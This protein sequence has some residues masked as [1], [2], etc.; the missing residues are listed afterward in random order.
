MVATKLKV[1]KTVKKICKNNGVKPTTKKSVTIGKKRKLSRRNIIRGTKTAWIFFCNNNRLDVLSKNPKLSFGD[2]CKQLAPQ[3]KVMSSEEKKPYED[4][5]KAD[6]VRFITETS[7]LTDDEKRT[8]KQHKKKKRDE[9]KNNPKAGLSPYMYFVLK[10]RPDVVTEFPDF[11]FQSVGKLLG[12]KWNAMTLDEK[13]PFVTLS[14]IDKERYRVELAAKVASD[15]NS[16]TV[17][18]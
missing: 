18:K 5:H 8:L 15:I 17:K 13:T 7:N 1:N 16:A 4:L 6:K 9:R 2:V 10:T 11:N 14:N 3:W 12:K